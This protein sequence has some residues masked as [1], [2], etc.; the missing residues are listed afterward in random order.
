MV[1][2]QHTFVDPKPQDC[3]LPFTYKKSMVLL[4]LRSLFKVTLVHQM[5][6]Y[7]HWNGGYPHG[8]FLVGSC[9]ES[10][11]LAG[12]QHMP[13]AEGQGTEGKERLLMKK[14]K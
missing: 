3:A 6:T 5:S 14:K 7:C 9:E 12:A 2:I 8:Q 4:K 1:G 11:R 10:T 13:Y